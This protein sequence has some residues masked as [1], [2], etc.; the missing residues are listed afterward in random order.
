MDL[1]PRPHGKPLLNLQVIQ[2]L[3]ELSNPIVYETVT[4]LRVS[5]HRTICCKQ[6]YLLSIQVQI[7]QPGAFSTKKITHSQ[8]Y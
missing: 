1:P 4:A 2:I 7:D 5:D 3:Q 6:H 8:Q